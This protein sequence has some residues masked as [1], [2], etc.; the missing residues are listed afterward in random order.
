M[1][2]HYALSACHILTTFLIYAQPGAADLNFNGSGYVLTSIPGKVNTGFEAGV[3]QP[4][5][6]IIA[7]GGTDEFANYPYNSD[8]LIVR[9]NPDGSADATFGTSGRTVTDIEVTND[10]FLAVALQPDGK[11]VAAG[12]AQTMGDSRADCIVV[13]YNPDGSLDNAFGN[14][15]KVRI[16]FTY[17]D[18]ELNAVAIQP[19]GKIVIVGT[20]RDEGADLLVAR[21]NSDGSLDLSF[22]NQGKVLIDFN[23]SSEIET[24][25]MSGHHPSFATA[26]R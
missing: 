14:G 12:R 9:Y 26:S 17:Y 11:I 3:A 19:D 23:S 18:D 22:G 7:V 16:T 13:R 20:Y 5:G 15:G 4:D 24:I 2:K 25:F 1:T 8:A 10:R 6:K 21:L